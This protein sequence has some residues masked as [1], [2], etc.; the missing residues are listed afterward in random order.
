MSTLNQNGS[1]IS[2][3]NSNTLDLMGVS[4]FHLKEY[5]LQELPMVVPC[6]LD[7]NNN[8]SGSPLLTRDS[9]IYQLEGPFIRRKGLDLTCPLDGRPGAAYV[10]CLQGD[11]HCGPATYMLSYSWG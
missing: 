5:L 3:R 6:C 2:S 11:D 7:E 1:G 10:H 9:T 4:V 8:R